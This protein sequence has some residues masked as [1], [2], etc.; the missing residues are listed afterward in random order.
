MLDFYKK[1]Y[2][3]LPVSQCPSAPHLRGCA[4]TCTP[5]PG[6]YQQPC[7]QCWVPQAVDGGRGIARACPAANG[8]LT[9]THTS[10]LCQTQQTAISSC[11]FNL[12][13]I[14]VPLFKG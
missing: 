14:H 13:D 9:H 6:G 2:M 1:V 11:P 5:E 4:G 8:P 12:V 3:H 10:P 7:Q